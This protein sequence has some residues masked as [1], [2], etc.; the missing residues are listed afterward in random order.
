MRTQ[1]LATSLVGLVLA[2]ACAPDGSSAATRPADQRNVLLI[3]SDD[4]GLQAGCYGNKVIKTPNL[5]R[6]A[7]GGVRFTHAFATVSS[8]SASRSVI[9][10]GL[11]N[12][13]NGQYGHQHSYHNF[14]TFT[15]VESL[16]SVLNKQGYRTAILAKFHVQPASVYP[17]EV[18]RAGGRD[19]VGVA[20]KAK[21]FISVEPAK[22]FCLVAAYSD[23]HRSRK[24]FGD[25][26][27][28]KGVPEFDY[29]PDEVIVPRWLPDTPTVR[30]ELVSY[31]RA[32]S[33]MDFGVG[34]LLNV[35]EETGAADNTLVIYISDNGPAFPGAKTNL[36][37]P[38]IH[39][40][41][42][43]RCP[44]LE[45]GGRVN[46]AMVSWVDITPT[47]LDWAGA[48]QPAKIQGRSFLPVLGQENPQGWDTV[49]ASHTFHEITM[50]YPMRVIRTRDYKYILNLAHPLDYPFASDLYAS[51]TWQEV[52]KTGATHYGPR[53]VD[54]YIHRPREELYHLPSDPDEVKNLADD[55]AHRAALEQ[56][57][58]KLKAWQ[59]KTKDPWVVKYRYE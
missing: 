28:A 47:I 57:R 32:V 40:P 15:W 45:P 46:H 2:L 8:C 4:H 52:L 1:R 34:L 24:G 16:P 48:K 10:T 51:P 56:L 17:F 38:G 42:I 22:P 30:K 58:A 33:R 21:E 53:A 9:Y 11:Y 31:Y 20:R 3:V 55:P 19:P 54:A 18:I 59:Q 26:T 25:E 29:T 23:P 44:T 37:E 5:D 27:K 49:F 7:A 13:A 43:V 6:L 12:H 50:Y 35:L 41:M 36:Y 39:L 14:H